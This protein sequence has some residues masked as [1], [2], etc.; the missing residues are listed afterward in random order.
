[1]GKCPVHEAAASRR[2]A[3]VCVEALGVSPREAASG[4]DLGGNLVN[5]P[6]P[7]HRD[8][9]SQ[10]DQRGNATEPRNANI[11][12]G[13]SSLFFV[14]VLTAYHGIGLPGDMDV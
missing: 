2:A 9:P 10:A 12:P 6:E 3:G 4:A 5:I 8:R 7:G 1:M 14:R 13:K 11:G